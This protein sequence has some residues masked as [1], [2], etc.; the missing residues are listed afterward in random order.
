MRARPVPLALRARVERELARLERDG[1]IYKVNH[2]DF[3]TPIVPVVKTNG[4]L[5]LCGDYKITINPK[6]KRDFYPLP[7]IEELFAN[8]SNGQEFTKIDLRHAYEQVILTEN[9]QRFTTITTHMGTFS[10]R[11]TPYGLSCVPEKFQ[12]LMEETLRGVPGTV[13]FLDDICV[14]GPDRHAHLRNLR[15]VLER[16]RQMGLTV[17][18]DKCRFLQE[19]VHYLGFI[20]DKNGLHP[21]PA[22]LEAL[23]CLPSPTDVT[24]LKSFLGLLNYY[25]KFIP[26]L[27]TLLHPL[28]ALL[29]KNAKWSWDSNCELAFENAKKSLVRDCVL[30]H[31]EEGRALV[32]S[33]DSSAYG[34]GAILAH[35]Y[36][37]GSERPVSCASRTLN[38]AEKN[39]S[40]LDKEALAIFYGVTKHH[41]YLFGRPF[42]L[43]TD[44]KPLMYIFGEKKGIP[45]TAASRLQRWAARLAGYDYKI[46]FVRSADNGPADSLSRLPLSHEHRPA[47]NTPC[48]NMLET[49]PINFRNVAKETKNDPLLCRILGYIMF[50][51]PLSPSS[52]EEKAFFSRKE[53][54]YTELGCILFKYRIVI[55]T[56]LRE[57]VLKE[58]HVGHIGM[59]KMKSLAR[60]YV[61]WPNLDADIEAT[62]RACAT[63]RAVR[64][65]PPRAPLHPWEFPLHPWR[66]I[67]A[68]FFDCANKRFL[69]IIDA[70]SKWVEVLLMS[71]TTAKLTI[72]AFRSVFAR[73]GLPS[74]LVTDNG[75]PFS[76]DE[77]KLYCEKNSIKHTTSAPYRP[78]GNGEAKNAVKTVKKAVKRAIIE[79]E[80][81]FD[82]L[83]RFLF[84]YRNCEHA[85]TGV[86][87]AVALL[88]RRLRGRLDA[89]RPDPAAAAH[90]AQRSQQAAAGG[91]Y[92]QFCVGQPVLARDYTQ[93]GN[94]WS[95]GQIAATTG[96]VSYKVDVGNGAVWRRHQDQIIPLGK[97]HRYS[98]SQANILPTD[99]DPD[100]PGG[101]GAQSTAEVADAPAASSKQGMVADSA[102]SD[103]ESDHEYGYAVDSSEQGE[104]VEHSAVPSAASARDIRAHNRAIK[105]QRIHE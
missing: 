69:I 12:K 77:F 14:T 41:Q 60:N 103:T 33:V 16:L 21:D 42:I 10:Y 64:D 61:Y 70:H 88:G 94:K 9:S 11:R 89:L 25:G 56:T 40:Q 44:H 95:E 13:V 86:A 78:Q 2:S 30:A 79:G 80:D 62:G 32:L 50:G 4:E 46:E 76:S 6:L 96:P 37:D 15:L 104:N 97:P 99:L 48:Y 51:W 75:P 72:K 31:Y 66:R 93:K 84:Q 23:T 26:K 52:E 35:R 101:A 5:R 22:K 65:A 59:N 57:K 85:T 55:P 53:E 47:S 54:L 63:C 27:S 83:N 87:P 18:L 17:K 24:Q 98:L 74:Q 71:G 29:K 19:R 102:K 91:R 90:E 45:Q 28:H 39:Y 7:R 49:M 3:G 1:T 67:H 43:R 68:D 92:R 100:E 73:F 58:I 82:A 8:L 34:V 36:A 81:I 105:K 38:D 20:I